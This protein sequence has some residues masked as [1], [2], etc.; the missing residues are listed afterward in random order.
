MAL[1]GRFAADFP[2]LAASQLFA[3]ASDI[4]SYPRFIPWCRSARV[5]AADGAVR[6]VDNHF[7][8]GPV[9]M[10]F[11]TRAEADEPRA[12]SITS[13]DGPFRSFRLDWRFADGHVEADYSIALRSPLLQGLAV[14]AMPEVE[15]RIVSQ[16][17]QR[18]EALHGA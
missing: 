5:L 16:F 3:I 10:R 11:V 14:F 13:D 9:D 12:L 2:G 4:E 8:A 15:R 18:V 6:R 1:R 17:R 7:G